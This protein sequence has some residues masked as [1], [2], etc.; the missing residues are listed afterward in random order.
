MKFN[1]DS[2]VES[3][4]IHAI[5][6]SP[7]II[8]PGLPGDSTHTRTHDDHDGTWNGKVHLTQDRMGDMFLQTDT[9]PY[10]SL[11]FR[12]RIG[13]TNSP[14]VHNAFKILAEAIRLDNIDRPE[15]SVIK[16]GK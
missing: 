13:G 16:E 7:A 9:H 12:N 11:R 6:N 2:G 1:P 5:L 8:L 10:E 4:V 14:R 15:P 3:D